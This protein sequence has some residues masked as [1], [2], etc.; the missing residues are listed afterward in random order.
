MPPLF[1]L[2]SDLMYR[3]NTLRTAH[4]LNSVA[5]YFKSAEQIVVLTTSI[6]AH[7]L[8]VLIEI[9]ITSRSFMP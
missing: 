4:D 9:T 3:E 8:N 7:S 5:I 1:I 2:G 6:L